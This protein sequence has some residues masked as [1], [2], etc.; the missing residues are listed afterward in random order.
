MF[1][2]FIKILLRTEI[3]PIIYK[4]LYHK[5]I[6]KQGSEFVYDYSTGV[7]NNK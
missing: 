1:T 2:L 3:Y 4:V 7:K 5:K 6:K